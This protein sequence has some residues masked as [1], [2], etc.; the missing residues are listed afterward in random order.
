MERLYRQNRKIVQK[1]EKLVVALRGLV[2]DLG[3]NKKK[4]FEELI[5]VRRLQQRR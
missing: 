3:L 4:E 2:S 1:N 5:R